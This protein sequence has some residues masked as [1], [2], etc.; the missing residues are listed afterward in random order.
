MKPAFFAP[1]LRTI[2]R[3]F[4]Y[5]YPFYSGGYRLAELPLFKATTPDE[6][7]LVYL[8]NRRKLWVNPK[9]HVGRNIYFLRELDPRVTFVCR[10]L[11]EEGDIFMDIGANYGLLTVSCADILRDR[12]EIHAFEPNPE[13]IDIL[14]KNLTVNKINNVFIH[15]VGLSDR[16]GTAEMHVNLD[17]LGASS[18]S[19]GEAECKVSIPIKNSATIL[20]EILENK[21]NPYLIKIDV[22]GHE[23]V[24]INSAK[25][26]LVSR[27]P[28]AIIFE[29]NEKEKIKDS[30]SISIF[31]ILRQMGMVIY[32]I[33]RVFT[34]PY[35]KPLPE[36]FEILTANDYVAVDETRIDW[37]KT[38]IPIHS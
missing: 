34:K 27:K 5:I 12:G 14:K 8:K 16:D 7:V 32:Y 19:R 10:S 36:N 1:F 11:L 13:V 30:E 24:I 35:L 2:F 29:F 6:L 4:G 25:Q 9:E 33:P 22:E 31:N 21:Q 15:A 3:F 20:S 37:V 18:L 17:N 28:K 38:R 26:F 23:R